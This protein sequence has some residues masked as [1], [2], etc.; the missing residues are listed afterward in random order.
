MSLLKSK[1]L[2]TLLACSSSAG[3]ASNPA[4]A[5]GGE[6]E[7]FESTFVAGAFLGMTE[8]TD[9]TESTFGLE[10]EYHMTKHVGMGL[11]FEHSPDDGHGYQMDQVI[12]LAELHTNFDVR[13]MVGP[14]I[15][16]SHGHRHALWR[17]GLAYDFHVSDFHISPPGTLTRIDINMPSLSCIDETSPPS[18]C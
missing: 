10:A 12:L 4:L 6:S 11:V 15:E 3:L 8:F 7:K 17:A 14:G 9:T 2:L 1:T 5:G 16:F 18:A 13:F